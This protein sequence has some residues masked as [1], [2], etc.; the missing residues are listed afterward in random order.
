VIVVEKGFIKTLSFPPLIVMTQS[1]GARADSKKLT[2][3]KIPT[4]MKD[5]DLFISSPHVLTLK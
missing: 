4:L 5:R 1:C 2:K 3:S